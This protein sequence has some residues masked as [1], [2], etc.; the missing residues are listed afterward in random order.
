MQW[1]N[2]SSVSDISALYI[3][4][5]NFLLKTDDKIYAQDDG[6]YKYF[7]KEELKLEMYYLK[8]NTSEANVRWTGQEKLFTK[9]IFYFKFFVFKFKNKWDLIALLP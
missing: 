6:K 8:G 4:T 2:R 7:I 1:S 9:D 3:I 5:T